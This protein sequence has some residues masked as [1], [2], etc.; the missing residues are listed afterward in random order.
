MPFQDS[1]L[2]SQESPSISMKTQPGW[3]ALCPRE[4]IETLS[5]NVLFF[6]P[7]VRGAHDP[8]SGLTLSRSIKEEKWLRGR[9][10]KAVG[11]MTEKEGNVLCLKRSIAFIFMCIHVF[12]W[13]ISGHH[14]DDWYLEVSEKNIGYLKT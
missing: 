13:H 10:T 5:M 3:D 12:A 8:T 11:E 4:S 7:S 9:L 1:C 6:L 14:M 2:C